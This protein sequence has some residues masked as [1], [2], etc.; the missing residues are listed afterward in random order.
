M[1][2]SRKNAYIN[3]LS[4]STNYTSTQPITKDKMF[5]AKRK[6]NLNSKSKISQNK[7]SEQ[8]CLYCV[9]Q[10]FK[11]Q[12]T[13]C[14]SFLAALMQRV[15]SQNGSQKHP[16]FS[17]AVSSITKSRTVQKETHKCFQITVSQKFLF[18]RFE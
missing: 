17:N 11:M 16:C 18:D 2:S 6:I 9:S 15:K 10:T 13:F 14:L 1:H 3:H 12:K 5:S 4:S 7:N 8:L